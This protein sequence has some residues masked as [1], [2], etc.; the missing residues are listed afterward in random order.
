MLIAIRI[1]AMA[2][3]NLITGLRLVV[4]LQANLESRNDCVIIAGACQAG[5]LVRRKLLDGK[6]PASNDEWRD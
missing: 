1:R 2:M 3:M 6:E 5:C 4:V